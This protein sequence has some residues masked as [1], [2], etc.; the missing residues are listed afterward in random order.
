MWTFL[1]DFQMS[2][3]DQSMFFRYILGVLQ[4]SSVTIAYGKLLLNFKLIL[5]NFYSIHSKWLTRVFFLHWSVL[6]KFQIPNIDDQMMLLVYDMIF[7]SPESLRWPIA[8]GWRPSSCVV[9]YPSC[10]GRW[11]LLLRN[12]WANP[13]QIWYVAS[14]G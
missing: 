2:M 11:H 6:I 14:I 9:R 8:M 12:Y 13:N 10:V 4:L 5:L 1:F 3:N 7:R